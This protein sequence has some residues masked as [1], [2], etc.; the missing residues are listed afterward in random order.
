MELARQQ[1]PPPEKFLRRTPSAEKPEPLNAHIAFHEF[2]KYVRAVPGE[3]KG[4]HIFFVEDVGYHKTAIQ[5]MERAMLAVVPIRPVSRQTVTPASR[6]AVHQE[7]DRAFSQ[8][9]L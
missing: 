4:S 2:M 9:W 1:K 3:R 6:S 5:E 8:N 7:R